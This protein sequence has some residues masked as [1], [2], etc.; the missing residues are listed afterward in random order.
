MVVEHVVVG[1][2]EAA[3]LPRDGRQSETTLAVARG[4]SRLFAGFGYATLPEVTL[5]SGRRADLLALGGDGSLVIVEIKSSIED[6]RTDA[7]WPDYRAYSDRLFFA[8][9]PHVPP[10]IMPEDA[11]LIVADAY[12]A[13]VLREAPEHRLPA[14]TR[15]ALLVRFGQVAAV[16]LQ[17]LLDPAALAGRD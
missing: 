15:K 7:K 3:P 4:V 16:R 5:A 17:G 11:G 6:F 10:E 8:I 13:E 2:G 9:P 1:I 12:G 14:A